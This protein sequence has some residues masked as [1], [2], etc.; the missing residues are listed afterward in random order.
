MRFLTVCF[1]NCRK[2]ILLC[3]STRGMIDIFRLFF[4]MGIWIIVFGRASRWFLSLG[5]VGG[6]IRCCISI[7]FQ[8]ISSKWILFFCIN[9]TCLTHSNVLETARSRFCKV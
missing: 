3:S 8:N 4:I 2:F 7:V 9:V 5:A 1:V 6:V